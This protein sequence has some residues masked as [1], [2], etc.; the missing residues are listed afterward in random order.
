MIE[1]YGSEFKNLIPK[2]VKNEINRAVK[3]EKVIDPAFISFS[4][5]MDIKKE[6][7]KMKNDKINI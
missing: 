6:E 2:Y 5:F 4:N 7:E 1:S 3:K